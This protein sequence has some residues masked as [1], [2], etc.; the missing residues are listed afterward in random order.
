MAVILQGESHQNGTITSTISWVS[1]AAFDSNLEENA[2]K[3]K[4][5]EMVKNRKRF[6]C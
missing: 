2:N 3:K 6:A 1:I 4:R 5:I